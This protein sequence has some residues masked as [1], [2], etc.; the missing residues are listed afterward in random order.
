MKQSSLSL[1]FLGMFVVLILAAC[2]QQ[3]VH[4]Q[5]STAAT[6]APFSLTLVPDDLGRV[7]RP[8]THTVNF[9]VAR[10]S[11]FNGE[12]QLSSPN[13]FL[14]VSV[15]PV[16]IASNQS[17]GSFTVSVAEESAV[18][19]GGLTI[20]IEDTFGETFSTNLG[21]ETAV[22]GTLDIN[23]DEDGLVQLPV[24]R[25]AVQDDNKIVALSQLGDAP[26]RDILVT[27]F[28]E[29]GSLDKTFGANGDGT[30][31]VD[32]EN[33][34]DDNPD[35]VLIANGDIIVVGTAKLGIKGIGLAR[36]NP[37]GSFDNSFGGG[38]GTSFIGS[39][40]DAALFVKR[41]AVNRDGKIVIAGSRNGSAIVL[42]ILADG[43]QLDTSFGGFGVVS[44]EPKDIESLNAL[45]LQGSK[46][47]LAGSTRGLLGL[48]N[49]V[50]VARLTSSGNPDPTFQGGFVKIGLGSTGDAITDITLDAD[51]RI[52]AFGQ[53]STTR[54]F[55]MRLLSSGELD[56][57]FANGGKLNL[58]FGGSC[59]GC[60]PFP[61]S[62]GGFS[63]DVA[64]Q[65]DN[66]PLI[67]VSGHLLRF[68][69]DGRPDTSIGRDGER[70]FQGRFSFI[71]QIS[72]DSQGRILM[73]ANDSEDLAV[74]HIAR[75]FP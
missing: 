14:G 42:R 71:G 17:S 23:F 10:D 49:D 65:A 19:Y 39:F 58:N 18:I 70:D 56:D 59:F 29:D 73:D 7:Q 46:I 69:E 2:T 68:M 22:S 45:E 8:S 32:F 55:L 21:I 24:I 20:Q 41:A 12:L 15:T 63:T 48:E 47:L 6:P 38:D 9:T 13:Q 40:E 25:F 3:G 61:I 1:S 28:N 44:F 53:Q 35:D 66:K 16:F 4:E 60:Y 54:A 51:G 64:V 43:S 30:V 74:D 75:I 67:G 62:A 31:A 37:D 72:L 57:R 27:R 26:N 34:S 36:L 5:L 33:G 52:V 50:I 11:G